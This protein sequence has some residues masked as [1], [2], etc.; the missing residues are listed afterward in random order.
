MRR[1]WRAAPRHAEPDADDRR[2]VDGLRRGA[3]EAFAGLHDRHATGIYNLALRMLRNA[4]DAE[5]V[6]QDVLLRAYQRL[7]RT[8]E[9]ALRPWLYRLTVNCCYDH[10]R[11][12]ARRR[13]PGVVAEREAASP[14]DLFEQSDL[15]R[16]FD[17]A[18]QS[19]TAR[20]RAAL[21]LKDVHGLSLREVAS[22]LDLT[23]GSVEVLLARARKAFRAAFADLCRAEGRSVPACSGLLVSAALPLLP[24]PA[25]LQAA[26]AALAPAALSPP[27]LASTAPPT[28]PVP[29]AALPAVPALPPLAASA[30]GLGA[31]FAAPAAVKTAAAIIAAAAAVTTASAVGG[32]GLTWH[33]PA[34]GAMP[35]AALPAAT[36]ATR[37]LP[38]STN[39]G[40]LSASP[41]ASPSASASASSSPVP[42][43]GDSGALAQASRTA[44]P[45]PGDP[46]VTMPPKATESPSAPPTPVSTPTADPS[47]TPTPTPTAD[48]SPSS[49]AWP[50][51]SPTTGS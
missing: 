35:V 42:A 38:L 26:P 1:V 27:A 47:A 19:L 20:Q 34:T 2:L 51:P 8:S 24:L 31:L 46:S 22:T 32:P 14:H 7:P 21:L 11:A 18:L 41:K 9:V 45:S 10:M 15:S 12:A 40:A 17:T 30:G 16:L 25:A 28:P 13:P 5:D 36:A 3:P 49:S 33:Q 29:A 37:P 48:P 43:A 4:P 50:S 44:S 23:P 39:A 6:T